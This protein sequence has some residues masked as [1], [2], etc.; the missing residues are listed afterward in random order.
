M[1]DR[2]TAEI[3]F[4]APFA[5]RSAW[6]VGRSSA[7]PGDGR[8][9]GDNKLDRIGPDCGPTADGVFAARRTRGGTW[10]A[11]L[12]STEYAPGGFELLPGDELTATCV[13]HDVQ[14]A[15]PALWTWGRDTGGRSQP[16]HGE[17][18][19]FE[20]HP[21]NPGL[22]ELTN[23]VRPAACYAEDAV[24]AGRP[25]ALRVVFG[26]VSV[27]WYADERLLFA[28][29]R[30]VGPHWRA[31]PIVCVSVAAGRYGHLPPLPGTDELEWQCTALTVR[32][33]VPAGTAATGTVSDHPA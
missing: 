32:R 10:H 15:W 13:V 24:T 23:H 1:T 3:V 30:G 6:A 5:D 16:G 29:R 7:Y 22:L 33:P 31:W 21:T 9:P 20:Y 8:N 19:A 18:D 17:I 25:F 12:V 4:D 14:G 28:D 11:A 27:E 26:A 2:P